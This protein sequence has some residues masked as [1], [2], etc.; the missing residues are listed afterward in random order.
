M[1]FPV[2]Q[3]VW[4]SV[5]ILQSYRQF[6][7]G[8]FFETQCSRLTTNGNVSANGNLNKNRKRT[9]TKRKPKTSTQL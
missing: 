6:K 8:N 2:V 7:G 5:K 1:H 4:K 9:K 3:Y